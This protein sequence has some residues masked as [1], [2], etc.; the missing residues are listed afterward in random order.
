MSGSLA[1]IEDRVRRGGQ[2]AGMNKVFLILIFI[3]AFASTVNAA[4][5]ELGVNFYGFSYHPD[6]KDSR[7]YNF[8][9]WNP[10]LGYH[11]NFFDNKHAILFADAGLFL[12]SVSKSTAFS[13]A[14]AEMKLF[15]GLSGGALGGIVY[16]PAYNSGKVVVALLP[17]VSFRYES[18][19]FNCT[20]IPKYK[21]VN[22]NSAFGFSVTWFVVGRK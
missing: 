19:R 5:L 3:F 2:S 17:S 12:N 9:E 14:G 13:L 7:G 20:Y 10:G 8:R 21:D 6:R 1:R 4:P 11:L 15:S 22:R 16:S 18:L